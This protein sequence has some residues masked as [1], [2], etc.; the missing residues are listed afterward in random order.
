MKFLAEAEQRW[1]EEIGKTP[2]GEY[3]KN[4][5]ANVATHERLHREDDHIR[6]EDGFD[7]GAE[8]EANIGRSNQANSAE[9]TLRG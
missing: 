6:R 9:E 8:A 2:S 1:Y 5:R 7:V 4:N 3:R